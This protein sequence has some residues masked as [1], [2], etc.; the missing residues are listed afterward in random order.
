MAVNRRGR[1]NAHLQDDAAF[2][3]NGR[4]TAVGQHPLV[5]LQ[6]HGG[7]ALT[8]RLEL[9]GG[10]AAGTHR[11]VADSRQTTSCTQNT[12]T[13]PRHHTHTHPHF[14][15]TLLSL[16]NKYIRTRNRRKCTLGAS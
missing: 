6:L 12:H 4:Q 9:A 13:L 16:P 3:I 14:V 8:I 7:E 2:L 10:V 15:E 5:A 1:R 11:A